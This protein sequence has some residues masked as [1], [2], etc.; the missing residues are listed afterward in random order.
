MKRLIFIILIFYSLFSQS[1]NA[2]FYGQNN[3]STETTIIT[4]APSSSIKID[5]ATGQ[6][7]IRVDWDDGNVDTYP[8]GISISNPVTH[9]YSS[10]QVRNIVITSTKLNDLRSTSQNINSVDISENKD[11]TLAGFAGNNL[12]SIDISENL[13]LIGLIVN[14]NQL[15]SID[16]SNNTLLTDIRCENNNLT[17]IDVSNNA[18]LK[19]LGLTNNSITSINLSNNTDLNLLLLRGNS[20]SSIDISSNVNLT[21]LDIASNSL[22]ALDVSSNTLLTRL[23][24]ALNSIVESE[25]NDILIDLDSFGL[26]D[27]TLEMQNNTAPTG[28]GLTAKASLQGKGWTVVSD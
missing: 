15:S 21:W 17:S 16:V 7:M 26:S 13:K 5:N 24:C 23:I 2:L 4:Q 22:T 1:Q 3:I 11:L 9:V 18:D 25:I 19:T 6:G 14:A 28:L 10:S 27:G 20:F 8:N 12:T